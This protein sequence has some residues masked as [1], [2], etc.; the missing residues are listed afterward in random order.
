MLANEEPFEEN[1]ESVAQRVPD[2]DL[3]T[4]FT[5]NEKITQSL[6]FASSLYS[7]DSVSG[8]LTSETIDT[9]K[10]V[11]ARSRKKKKK[12]TTA[13]LEVNPNCIAG[14]MKNGLYKPSK[15]EIDALA[16]LRVRTTYARLID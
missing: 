11:S 12:T 4:C 6:N 15:S 13:L 2:S 9:T 3:E 16:Q 7:L 1:F 5:E 14:S 8:E 10:V